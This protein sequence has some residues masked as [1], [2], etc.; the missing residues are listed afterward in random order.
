[1]QQLRPCSSGRNLLR[2]GGHSARPCQLHG[3]AVKEALPEAEAKRVEV[4][5]VTQQL[6]LAVPEGQTGV[7][8]WQRQQSGG[9][10]ELD[11]T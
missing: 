1:M 11:R 9:P 3:S 5:L 8:L 10:P 6:V 2:P 4:E 7:G